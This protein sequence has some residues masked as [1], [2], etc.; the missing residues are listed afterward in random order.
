MKILTTKHSETTHLFPSRPA[1]RLWRFSAVWRPWVLIVT[2]TTSILVVIFTAISI[3]IG[4]YPL[5][6]LTVLRVMFLHQG[7]DLERVIVMDWRMPRA[8]TSVAVGAALG[9]S[10]ALMQSVTRN[11]LASPDILGIT[12]GASAAAVTVI[13]LTGST[14]TFSSLTGWMVS[15]GVPFVALLGGFLTGA[16]IWLLALQKGLDPFRLVLFGIITTALL[17]AYINFLL[18]RAKLHDANSAQFWL[19]GSLN[20]SNWSRTIPISLALLCCLP[21]IAWI[22]FKLLAFSLGSDLAM[23]LGQK[24]TATNFLILATSVALASIAVSASGPI[25]FIAFVAPQLALRA[26]RLSTPPLFN[27][28]LTGALLLVGADI[29]AQGVLP[30]DLPVGIITSAIGGTFLIYLLIKNNRRNNS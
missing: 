16:I 10:G 24:V 26:C 27:S 19:S 11:S 4:D 18:V 1:W 13:T 22:S 14:R 5:S 20:S 9:L 15:A 7:S 6:P 17:N 3:G 23:A 25:G 28:A 2:I 30:V 12:S 8:L 21:I 29:L